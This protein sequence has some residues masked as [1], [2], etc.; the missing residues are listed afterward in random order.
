MGDHNC[1]GWREEQYVGV[2]LKIHGPATN[3]EAWRRE[4]KEIEKEGVSKT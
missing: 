3:A 1:N 4:N 2:S